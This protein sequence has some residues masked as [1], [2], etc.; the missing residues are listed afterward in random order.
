MSSRLVTRQVGRTASAA[1]AAFENGPLV[2]ERLAA[3]LGPHAAAAGPGIDWQ[4][5][6]GEVGRLLDDAAAK[7]S[8]RDSENTRQ[9]QRLL[10]LRQQR[11][12]A[13]EQVRGELRS[14][15]F[16][17]DEVF[18]KSTSLLHFPTR[19]V[20]PKANAEFLLTYARELAELLRSD[21]LNW[22]AQ[23]VGRHLVPPG[24]LAA[25]LE[26]SAAALELPV[27]ALREKEKGGDA[28]RDVKNAELVSAG[29][30]L[31][32]GN[33]FLFGIYRLAGL[34]EAAGNLRGQRRRRK[35]TPPASGNPASG[36]PP[37]APLAL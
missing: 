11:D 5:S 36:E 2:A 26:A 13:A 15:R 10:Q 7:L 1:G 21:R 3:L 35:A 17:F 12:A 25:S 28:T 27:A 19:R 31:R 4:A 37:A 16:L 33:D 24:E 23:E 18:G 14:L 34:D 30:L 8:G 32:R 20:L 9:R 6:L 29:D 22:P